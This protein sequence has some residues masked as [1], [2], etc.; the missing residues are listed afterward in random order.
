MDT[1]G[2]TS[3]RE[4]QYENEI[5]GTRG[6]SSLRRKSHSG[7]P[8]RMTH[9]SQQAF[10]LI[11]LFEEGHRAQVPSSLSKIG[12]FAGGEKDDRRRSGHIRLNTFGDRKAVSSRQRNVEHHGVRLCLH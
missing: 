5:L 7:L 9:G 11:R 12:A 4:S 8:R 3:S 6:S 10:G 2:G 1:F